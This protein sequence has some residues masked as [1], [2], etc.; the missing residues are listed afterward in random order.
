MC[1][2][3]SHQTVKKSKNTF[4]GLV[5]HRMTSNMPEGCFRSM[6]QRMFSFSL[7]LST[8]WLNLGIS[9]PQ[10]CQRIFSCLAFIGRLI[11]GVLHLKPS[12][13]CW[14]SG[15]SRSA[16][17]QSSRSQTRGLCNDLVSQ[18]SLPQILIL[19]ILGFNIS[20]FQILSFPGGQAIL[21]N[22]LPKKESLRSCTLLP[23]SK[24]L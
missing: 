15:T 5:K 1:K 14:K 8:F 17:A 9:S 6:N 3:L 23:P 18:K 13:L 21:V 16:G 22:H 11:H 20:V 4:R 19:H 7:F 24:L 2:I 10:D 12:G